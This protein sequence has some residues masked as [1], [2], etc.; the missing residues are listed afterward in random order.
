MAITG[1]VYLA[2]AMPVVVGG[3]YW[4]QASSVGAYI[5]LF[6]GL[7]GIGALGP[8]IDLLQ[9]LGVPLDG[10]QVTILTFAVSLVGFVVGSLLFPDGDRERN[11][12]R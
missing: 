3:L 8:A 4:R 6:G 10:A 1:T 5:A 11:H 7:V 12:E 2:G 9:S